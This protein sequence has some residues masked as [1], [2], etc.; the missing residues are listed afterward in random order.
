MYEETSDL[1]SG[2]VVE[3][4]ETTH[5]FGFSG[6]WE[7]GRVQSRGLDPFLGL[8]PGQPPSHACLA[9]QQRHPGLPVWHAGDQE[10]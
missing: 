6:P 1:E 10:H 2:P 8:G 3:E 9:G 4:L 5:L 7:A